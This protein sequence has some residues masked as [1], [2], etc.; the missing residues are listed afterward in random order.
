[1]KKLQFVNWLVALAMVGWQT[2]SASALEPPTILLYTPNGGEVWEVG[3]TQTITWQNGGFTDIRLDYRTS[4]AAPWQLIVDGL[5][6]YDPSSYSWTIPNTPTTTAI[7]RIEGYFSHGGP[8]ERYDYSDNYFTIFNPA[9]SQ[10]LTVVRPNGGEFW[11]LGS[12]Q[13]IH[14]TSV[15][16]ERKAWI[17]IELNRGDKWQTIG[18]IPNLGAF[19]WHVTGPKTDTALIRVSLLKDPKINDLSD[20][21]FR[22][23][24]K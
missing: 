8:S 15:G 19:I 5:T 13:C 12:W 17:K 10:T 21:F 7:V 14:W 3:S 16:L 23:S 1:M 11:K 4:D 22:I 2:P 18:L 9:P 24:N 20:N 6:D